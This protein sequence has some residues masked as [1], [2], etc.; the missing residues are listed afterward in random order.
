MMMWKG[1]YDFE[2]FGD[3]NNP[4]NDF[5]PFYFSW[6]TQTTIGYGDHS[7]KTKLGKFLVCLQSFIFWTVALT[8]AILGDEQN[9]WYILQP[10][11]WEIPYSEYLMTSS[12][13]TQV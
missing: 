9:I 4:D 7:P 10:T 3:T 2:S 8:F 13:V 1:N 11:N 6:I 5:D 12:K